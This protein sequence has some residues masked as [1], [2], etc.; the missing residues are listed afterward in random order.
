MDHY[1]LHGTRRVEL[2]FLFSLPTRKNL[3]RLSSR[4]FSLSGYFSY[5]DTSGFLEPLGPGQFFS[6]RSSKVWLFSSSFCPDFDRVY[7]WGLFALALFLSINA[8]LATFSRWN[9]GIDERRYQNFSD[10]YSISR[11]RA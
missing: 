6:K 4:I 2:L 9:V 5:R 7:D 11:D 3:S 10:L 1:A 8:P